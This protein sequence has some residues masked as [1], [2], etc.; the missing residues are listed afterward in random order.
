[1][2]PDNYRQL[3]A[4]PE[5]ALGAQQSLLTESAFKEKKP[6]FSGLFWCRLPVV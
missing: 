6:A 5:D 1:M 2:T 4:T 3:Q